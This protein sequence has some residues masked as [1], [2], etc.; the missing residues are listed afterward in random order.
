MSTPLENLWNQYKD[1]DSTTHGSER[2]W[3]E[4]LCFQRQSTTGLGSIDF[5]CFSIDFCPL[6][7]FFKYWGYLTRETLMF[8]GSLFLLLK[9]TLNIRNARRG[10]YYLPQAMQRSRKGP[11]KFL[12]CFQAFEGCNW[13]LCSALRRTYYAEGG[14]P[15]QSSTV[16]C[17]AQRAAF[18]VWDMIA[19]DGEQRPYW[20]KGTA[21]FGS[22]YFWGDPGSLIDILQMSRRNWKFESLSL[23]N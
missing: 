7:F 2:L 3:K 6:D 20:S 1:A 8:P 5:E 4:Q 17:L 14:R 12:Q 13:A 11:R 23:G 15:G 22:C 16:R 21:G 9:E 10:F 18:C 19:R